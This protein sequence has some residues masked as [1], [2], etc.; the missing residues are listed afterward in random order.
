MA[1][2]CCVCRVEFSMYR[3]RHHCRHVVCICV[4]GFL[5]CGRVVC[6]SCSSNRI[7]GERACTPCW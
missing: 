4:W 2:T 6:D 5:F 3:R 7:R 1:V